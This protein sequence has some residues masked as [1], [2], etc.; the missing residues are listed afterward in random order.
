M[1]SS[2]IYI[3]VIKT[4]KYFFYINKEYE[5]KLHLFFFNTYLDLLYLHKC[6]YKINVHFHEKSKE[7]K[8]SRK[9]RK[10]F[11]EFYFVS[12]KVDAWI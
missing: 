4:I 10:S 3:S 5:I 12:Y 7:T 8:N 6:I 2:Y 1:L 11:T 9:I